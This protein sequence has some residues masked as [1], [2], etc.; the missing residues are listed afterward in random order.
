LA[1]RHRPFKESKFGDF[2]AQNASYLQKWRDFRGR[3]KLIGREK[4]ARERNPKKA[5]VRSANQAKL[6]QSFPV[7]EIIRAN[8]CE[9]PE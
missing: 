4:R 3:D 7:S 1:N 9:F 5:D 2:G 6:H 8:K